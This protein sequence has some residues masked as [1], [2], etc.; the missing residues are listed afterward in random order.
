MAD[1]AVQRRSTTAGTRGAQPTPPDVPVQQQRAPQA[2][3]AASVPQGRGLPQD[4]FTVAPAAAPPL[5]R[6]SVALQLESLRQA[7]RAGTRRTRGAVPPAAP[8]QKPVAAAPGAALPSSEIVRGLQEPNLVRQ[9]LAQTVNRWLPGNREL[10]QADFPRA[11]QRVGA[12]LSSDTPGRN[13]AIENVVGALTEEV[14][15]LWR[16]GGQHADKVLSMLG[17]AARMHGPGAAEARALV[18]Q[19][20]ARFVN[21][22]WTEDSQLAAD[23]PARRI[24]REQLASLVSGIVGVIRSDAPGVYGFLENIDKGGGAS[25]RGGELAIGLNRAL[26]RTHDGQAA[27][28]DAMTQLTHSAMQAQRGADHGAQARTAQ[29]LGYFTGTMLT[30]IKNYGGDADAQIAADRAIVSGMASAIRRI[31]G[32]GGTAASALEYLSNRLAQ[33]QQQGVDDRV[34]S[35]YQ[36][37]L[38]APMQA[39]NTLQ[40][41][42][43]ATF[44]EQR[45]NLFHD[46]YHNSLNHIWINQQ[47]RR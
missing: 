17:A 13:V 40:N 46:Q 35:M 44:N 39:F 34:N 26:L 37:F 9:D 10:S 1:G 18:A 12:A 31:P 29:D 43:P 42:D 15:R 38:T 3:S 28:G 5:P 8:V 20:A 11:L 24:Q 36:A 19:A 32:A 2:T 14:G 41:E 4:E 25:G 16:S 23:N 45:E 7:R 22:A 27:L 21:S 33:S 47:Q 30:A 6:D